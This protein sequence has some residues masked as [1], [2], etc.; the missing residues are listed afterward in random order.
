MEMLEL[1]ILRSHAFVTL[2]DR[3]N[4]QLM[5]AD[6]SAI[7][8]TSIIDLRT[9]DGEAM[10]L[11]KLVVFHW[12]TTKQWGFLPLVENSFTSPKE[13]WATVYY[14]HSNTAEKLGCL[15]KFAVAGWRR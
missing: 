1:S 13:N 10:F 5:Y 11:A 14:R 15:E 8:T 4:L 3:D 7:V 12:L 6:R 9:S 2:V